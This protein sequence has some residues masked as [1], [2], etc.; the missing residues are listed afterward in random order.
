VILPR[1]LA[2]WFSPA[3][4]R[5][6][7]SILIFHRVLRASDP[8]APDEPDASRFDEMLSWVAQ[9][10]R[11]LPLDTAI[12]RLRDGTLPARALSITFDDGY[13]D[14]VSVALPILVRNGMTATFFIS[15]GFLDGGR[16]WNDTVIEAIRRSPLDALDLASIGLGNHSL[17]SIADRRSAIARV[18]PSVKYLPCKERLATVDA[19]GRLARASLPGDLMMSTAQVRELRAAGMQIG[20][21]TRTHPIL[22]KLDPAQAE[23]EIG[24]GKTD[25]EAILDERVALFAYPNGKPARDYGAEH[26]RMV[27]ASGFDAAVSTSTGVARASTDRFQL[28]R[29][30]PWDRTQLRFG[31]RL[32]TN[33]RALAR[34][35]A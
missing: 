4:T 1:A 33:M 17:A 2:A 10:F 24:G 20:A 18:L 9:T 14:N 34:T 22:A 12:E 8:L 16:M 28:P 29:F 13:E 31:L 23:A 3:G 27:E 26:V 5:A 21:H 6:S 30:T 11:V 32:V 25:L 35:A 7:L 15:S 19:I